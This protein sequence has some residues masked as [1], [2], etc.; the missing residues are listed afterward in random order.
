MSKELLKSTT[1]FSSMTLLSRILGFI[2]DWST[3]HFFGAS[4]AYDAFIIAFKL[5]NIM[6]RLFAE[7]AFAQAFMPVFAEYHVHQSHAKTQ[8]MLSNIAGCLSLIL[9]VVCVLGMIFAKQ[10]VTVFAPG[11]YAD[12]QKLQ[13]AANML[14]LTFPYL[15]FIALTALVSGVLNHSKR[16]AAAAFV[17]VFL[18]LSM[19]YASYWGGTSKIWAI[20]EFALAWAVPFAGMIQLG[21]LLPYLRKLQFK[22]RLKFHWR[23]PGVQQTIKLM[24]PTILGAAVGQVNL[25]LDTVF[26]SFLATGA[27]SWLYYADRLMELPLGIFGV[28]IA[29]VAMP[30]LAQAAARKTDAEFST[31]IDWGLRLTLLLACPAVIGLYMLA[32]PLLATLFFNGRFG[33]HDVLHSAACLRAYAPALLGLMLVKVL[34]NIFYA[35]QRMH[36]TVVINLLILLLSVACNY[37]LLPYFAEVSIAITTSIAA[38]LQAA[39]LF[40][41]IRR[42]NLY[43]YSARWAYFI[44][45]LLLA[46]IA[47]YFAVDY[48]LPAHDFW[49]IAA[50]PAKIIKLASLVVLGVGSYFCIITA[51]ILVQRIK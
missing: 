29:T 5:P 43:H 18:N 37:C 27:I 47:M 15:L 12:T 22:L 11:F 34:S 23:H 40:W 45:W 42:H 51:S 16:F 36:T 41:Q 28:A 10:L 35:K 44:L 24:L 17:P 2:R 7:G 32:L 9:I 26:A 49:L 25:L 46:N 38:L 50:L 21:F 39:L 14:R 30:R 48:F 4:M 1:I 19:I 13:L 31:T 3:A 20:P 33:M 8:E 6:R